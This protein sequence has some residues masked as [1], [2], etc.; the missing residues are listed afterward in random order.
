MSADFI[1]Y[2]NLKFQTPLFFAIVKKKKEK[3]L[4][5]HK[6]PTTYIPVRKSR[7]GDHFVMYKSIKLLNKYIKQMYVRQEQ[8]LGNLPVQ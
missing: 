7:S 4:V 3:Q 2:V 6:A 5:L 8:L 1:N